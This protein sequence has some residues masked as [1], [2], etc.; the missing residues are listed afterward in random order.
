M[1]VALVA[2]ILVSES[3]LATW[4]YNST[5]RSVLATILF[6]HS[7]HHVPLPSSVFGLPVF[8]LVNVASAAAAIVTSGGS[9]VGVRRNWPLRTSV[10]PRSS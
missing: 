8:A 7:I 6:Y 4:L 5:G 2:T 9:L 3:V 1:H 10:Q